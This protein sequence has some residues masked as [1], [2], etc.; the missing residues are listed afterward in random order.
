MNQ[1]KAHIMRYLMQNR[2]GL[3]FSGDLARYRCGGFA[4]K[5]MKFVMP[6]MEAVR[7]S[8]A[9]SSSVCC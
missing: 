2:L 1:R 4:S 6:C 8:S 3:H 7:C 9:R 5:Q